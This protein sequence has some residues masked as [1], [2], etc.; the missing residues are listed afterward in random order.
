MSLQ[1]IV[2]YEH[3]ASIYVVPHT[4]VL[5]VFRIRC[6]K[7]NLDA[8]KWGDDCLC[9]EDVGSVGLDNPRKWMCTHDTTSNTASDARANHLVRGSKLGCIRAHSFQLEAH[10]Q[11]IVTMRGEERSGELNSEPE[12]S[13]RAESRMGDNPYQG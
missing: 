11:W 12:F 10:T 7:E 4:C 8:V 6:L 5:L 1:K 2:G 13:V 3:G 9:L